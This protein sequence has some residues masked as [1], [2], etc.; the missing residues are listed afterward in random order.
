MLWR[1][2]VNVE[3]GTVPFAA[4][5]ETLLSTASRYLGR[6]SKKLVRRFNSE[7][8]IGTAVVVEEDAP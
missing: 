5:V 4:Q 7:V 2:H 8:Q 1:T 6:D 3:S